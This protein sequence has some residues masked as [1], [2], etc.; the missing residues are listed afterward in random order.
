MSEKKEFKPLDVG[1]TE[2]LPWE[3]AKAFREYVSVDDKG[4]F[5][6]GA[7]VTADGTIGG[8]SGLKPIHIYT[9]G[10]TTL[11]VYFEVYDPSNGYTFIGKVADEDGYNTLV[12]GSY[13]LSKVGNL[14]VGFYTLDISDVGIVA[15]KQYNEG[16]GHETYELINENRLASSLNDIQLNLDNLNINFSTLQDEVNGKQGRLFRHVIQLSGDNTADAICR[17]EWLSPNN[18]KCDSL[19][20]LR[21]LLNNPQ[22]NSYVASDPNGDLFGVVISASTAQ[23]KKVGTTEL[24]NITNVS[25]TVTTL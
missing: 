10:A 12:Y 14:F 6:F 23:F 25:D 16:G 20:N 22:M 21:T 1:A 8:N 3:L 4:N 7:N 18:L 2:R 17:L 9:V 19:E 13:A 24:I 11:Y 15:V 5:T